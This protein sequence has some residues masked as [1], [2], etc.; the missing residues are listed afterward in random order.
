MFCLRIYIFK[1]K[2]T[3]EE[4]TPRGLK[5]LDTPEQTEQQQEG[6]KPGLDPS[7]LSASCRI[8]GSADPQALPWPPRCCCLAP[9]L[10]PARANC[11]AAGAPPATS[12]A[13]PAGAEEHSV[14]SPFRSAGS[15]DAPGLAGEREATVG[16]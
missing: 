7:P 13:V 12:A 11:A 10:S 5:E 6:S 8:E 4:Q 1:S 15:P 2:V 14:A 16:A 9:R 3:A